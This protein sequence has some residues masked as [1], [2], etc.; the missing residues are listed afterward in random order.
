MLSTHTSKLNSTLGTFSDMCPERKRFTEMKWTSIKIWAQHISC[1][2]VK[3]QSHK[4]RDTKKTFVPTS[5]KF[6]F[7][8]SKSD[9]RDK[10]RKL[11]NP[12]YGCSSSSL[13]TRQLFFTT[14]KDLST[15]GSDVDA[16][17]VKARLDRNFFGDRENATGG[18]FF[19]G[20]E[21]TWPNLVAKPVFDEGR[22]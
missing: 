21:R 12:F 13:T 5:F 22:R 2:H 15:L 20:P 9:E 18:R 8:F 3:N 19:S 17:K 4:T 6:F 1:Q 10:V 11:A 16:A 7:H 14:P